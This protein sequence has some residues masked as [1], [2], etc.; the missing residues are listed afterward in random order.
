M[1]EERKGA[2]AV[3]SR[4][5][6][7]DLVAEMGSMRNGLEVGMVE[8]R[9]GVMEA[10]MRCLVGLGVG[11]RSIRNGLEVGMVVMKGVIEL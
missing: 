10:E 11:M 4:R 2:M 3:E 6:L 5:C 9:I 8:E 7:V 1:E